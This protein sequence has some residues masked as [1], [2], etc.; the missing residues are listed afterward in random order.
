M[1]DEREAPQGDAAHSAVHVVVKWFNNKKGFGFVQAP[2]SFEGDAFLHI[3]VLQ[4]VG[5]S[6]LPEG[7]KLT[8]D[9]QRGDRG[10]QVAAVVSVDEIPAAPPRG[11]H[12]PPG[13]DLKSGPAERVEA[14][15][16]F[17]NQEKGFG[18]AVPDNGGP[19]IF[20]SARLLQRLRIDNLRPA[21]AMALMVRQ[22]PKGPVAEGLEL[23]P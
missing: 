10:L 6:D 3:S 18:F 23:L 14:T 9:L 5:H 20:I 7:T 1:S 11:P 21:Q 2:E 13:P 17:F 22:G 4:A 16:K 15:L 8:C 12:R 19:D